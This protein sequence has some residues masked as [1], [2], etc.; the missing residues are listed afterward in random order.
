MG[1]SQ[2]N[3]W[4]A[5]ESLHNWRADQRNEFRFIGVSEFAVE[6]AK[7]VKRGDFVFVYV[8]LPRSSFSDVRLILKAGV[9]RSPQTSMY[10]VPCY[11][12]LIT[13]PLLVLEDGKWLPIRS[14]IGGLSFVSLKAGWGNALRRNFRKV[15]MSNAETILSGMERLNL[16]LPW[17]EIRGKVRAA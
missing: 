16:S 1:S 9:H 14:I 8:P 11:A 7:E 12:G 10:D 4:M 6:R 2:Q 13:K 15:T 3:F 17:S 5:I